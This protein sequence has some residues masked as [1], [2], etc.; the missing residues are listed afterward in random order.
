MDRNLIPQTRRVTISAPISAGTGDTQ[1]FTEIDMRANGGA[2]EAV[3]CTVLLGTIT[4]SGTATLRV[5]QSDTSATYG[6]GTVDCILD[7]SGASTRSRNS[8][9]WTPRTSCSSAAARSPGWTR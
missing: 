7:A 6:S 8:C 3:I 9:R 1:T 5:K 4:G 2:F